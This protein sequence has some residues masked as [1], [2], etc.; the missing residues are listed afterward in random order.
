MPEP[1]TK[2]KVSDL[3]TLGELRQA[4]IDSLETPN[5]GYYNV[6]ESSG[7]RNIAR[8]AVSDFLQ[9]AGEGT[10]SYLILDNASSWVRYAADEASRLQKSSDASRLML[11]IS[12]V[13]EE[14]IQQF[15]NVRAG[16]LVENCDVR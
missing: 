9:V 12:R 16:A 10:D 3:T 2:F 6:A 7:I 1:I 8:R 14:V 15:E 11:Y 13:G 5:G 4:L